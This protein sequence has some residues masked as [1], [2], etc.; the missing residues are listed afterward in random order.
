MAI[1]RDVDDPLC[2]FSDRRLAVQPHN[3]LEPSELRD[4]AAAEAE[5]VDHLA[6]EQR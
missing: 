2:T 4:H 1:S 3:D 6:A 5:Q